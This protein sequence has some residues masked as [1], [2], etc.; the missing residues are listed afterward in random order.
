ML[1]AACISSKGTHRRGSRLL[2]G[3]LSTL[4][5]ACAAPTRATGPLEREPYRS[6]DQSF[7]V[8][9]P[10][11]WKKLESGHPYGD[12]TTISGVRLVGPVAPGSVPVTISVLHY[13]GEHLFRTPEEFIHNELNS[14][15]RIDDEH[16]APLTERRTARWSGR[17]FYTK[18]FEL[19]F[20]PQLNPQPLPEGVVV[21][22][23]PPHKRI[24]MMNQYIVIAAREGFFVLK[25]SAPEG[26]MK[27]N[28]SLFDDITES[29]QPL[30]H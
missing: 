10:R 9:V 27:I 28:Q 6:P 30:L 11:G 12:L 1:G 23:A 5:L 26:L 21:E 18:T 22:L 7:V 17:T 8:N 15:V 4:L 29:F 24:D 13:S 14:I 16:A 3:L 25:L 20:L 2:W 19:V